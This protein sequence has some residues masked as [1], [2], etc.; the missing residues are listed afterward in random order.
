MAPLLSRG[1]SL[2]P[3]VREVIAFK[4]AVITFPVLD[5]AV[6]ILKSKYFFVCY[7]LLSDHVYFAYKYISAVSCYGGVPFN[8]S[9]DP[10]FH[11]SSKY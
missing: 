5:S 7:N 9:S 8:N 4:D 10:S 1:K 3:L 11:M 2:Q 6:H